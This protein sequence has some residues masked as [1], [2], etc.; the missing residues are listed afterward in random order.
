MAGAAKTV[1]AE[2]ASLGRQQRREARQWAPTTEMKH[3]VLV[4]IDQA[5]G[6]VA[7][8]VV[9][10]RAAALQRHWPEKSAVEMQR[11]A[12]DIFLEATSSEAQ[13]ETYAAIV[14]V[15]APSDVEAM[16]TALRYI[17][18]W[19]VVEWATVQNEERKL[20]PSTGQL[21]DQYEMERLRLPDHVR[22]PARGTSQDAAARK[23]A[24]RLRE[25]WGGVLGRLKVRDDTPLEVKRSKASAVWQWWNHLCAKTPPGKSLLRVNLDET[26]I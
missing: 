21:L 12:E 6:A 20:A 7:H 5:E 9:Y 2:L 26:A 11:I 13:L 15:S 14:D 24:T 25:R 18:E 22:P 4:M 3:I 23:W 8:T 1:R 10:L 17:L 19:R 16:R